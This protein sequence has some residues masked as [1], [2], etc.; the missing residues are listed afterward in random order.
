MTRVACLVFVLASLAACDKGPKKTESAAVATAKS[1]E[2][3]KGQSFGAGVKLASATPIESILSEPT[4]FAGQT[5]RVEGIVTDVC[6]MRGCWFEMAGE[7][8]G[9]KL[10][11]KVTDGEMVFP[12]ESKGKHAVAEGVVAVHELSLEDSKE[13]AAEEARENNKPF[14][15]ASVTTPTRIVRLDGTGAVF[16]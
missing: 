9:Q 4:K 15:P 3:A 5:V 1:T 8:A 10:R 6:Q 16:N 14:D 13:Y 12:A 11:F 2:V 7:K